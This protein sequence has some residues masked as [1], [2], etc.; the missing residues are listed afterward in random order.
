MKKDYEKPTAELVS[1]LIDEEIAERE[2]TLGKAAFNRLIQIPR[3]EPP[4]GGSCSKP[5]E[6]DRL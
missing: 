6:R 5:N 2:S 1:L 4:F 3:Q